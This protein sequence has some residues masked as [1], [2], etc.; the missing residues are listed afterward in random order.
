[1]RAEPSNRSTGNPLG[2]SRDDGAPGATRPV[3]AMLTLD[4]QGEIL[5]ASPSVR[6]LLGVSPDDLAGSPFS[7]L[8]SEPYRHEWLAA[9]ARLVGDD[10][11]D[12]STDRREIFVRRPAQ[13]GVFPVVVST[14]GVRNGDLHRVVV[15]VR[16]RTRERQLERRLQEAEEKERRRIAHELHD[17][18]GGQLTGVELAASLLQRRLA[19]ENSDQAPAAD[20]IVEHLRELHRRLREVSRGLLPVEDDPL[21]L[22]TALRRLVKLQ[23][24]NNGVRC[25]LQCD[26]DLAVHD[27]GISTNL[28]SIAEEALQNALRHSGADEITIRLTEASGRE[29]VLEVIDNGCG[30]P[31]D[32]GLGSGIGLDGMA[33]RAHL[34]GAAFEVAALDPKGTC[35]RCSVELPTSTDEPEGS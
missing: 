30:I 19:A 14:A 34:I 15:I 31:T 35:V 26:P 8:V 13:E 3:E 22:A 33:Y 2:A 29:V 11:R 5:A 12:G 4:Q 6:T 28:Y 25:V 17:S 24:G 27:T 9:F 18:V 10:A 1:M 21:G 20:E 7:G 32:A 23:H 16:D